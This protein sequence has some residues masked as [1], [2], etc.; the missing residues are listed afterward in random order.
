MQLRSH[1][2]RQSSCQS[3]SHSSSTRHVNHGVEFC[4]TDHQELVSRTWL[5]L[6]QLSAKVLSS[7]SV[8]QT[9]L[10]SGWVSPKSSS[11]SSSRWRENKSHLSSLSMR[12]TPSVVVV[13][14]V[15]T[16]HQEESR[17]NS[18]S[19]CKVLATTWTVSL[20]SEPQTCPGNLTTL[21]VVVSR[22]VS[23]SRSL[24]P[25]LAQESS[26]LGQEQ[27]RT[28][29]L[30]LTGSPLENRLKATPAPISPSS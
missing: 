30:K 1:F 2:K 26:R 10:A 21:F 8:P 5:R 29:S 11:S 17:L 22:S 18:W 20:S 16:T 15:K 27:Q 4:C 25:L 23:I 13:A 28:L 14:R 6:V 9:W 12:S 24:I 7:R 3:D 19:R